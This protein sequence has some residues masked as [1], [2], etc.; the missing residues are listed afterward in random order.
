MKKILKNIILS[1]FIIFTIMSITSIIYNYAISKDAVRNLLVDLSEGVHQENMY[2]PNGMTLQNFIKMNY[3]N[4]ILDIL[5]QIS[6]IFILSIII[7]I[8]VGLTISVKEN[9]KIKYILYFIFGNILCNIIGGIIVQGIYMKYSGIRFTFFESFYE[10]FTGTILIYIILYIFII[11]IV[12]LD[13]KI[14]VNKLNKELKKNN[15]E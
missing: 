7:G 5:D 13:N 9:S 1:I 4:G 8:I 3:Y 10:S 6:N 15:K 2:I 11:L 14:K 12:R